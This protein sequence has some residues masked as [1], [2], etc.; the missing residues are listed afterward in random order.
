MIVFFI[1]YDEASS[2]V[3][4]KR[5]RYSGRPHA[6]CHKGGVALVGKQV[7]LL[8]EDGS[9]FCRKNKCTA[10]DDSVTPARLFREDYP[11][12]F[13][14]KLKA[15]L[16]PTFIDFTGAMVDLKGNVLMEGPKP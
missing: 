12:K 16:P 8:R 11:L 13:L 7:H 14:R 5:D 6:H 2:R 10:F 15:D 1:T 3:R 4:H 9:V